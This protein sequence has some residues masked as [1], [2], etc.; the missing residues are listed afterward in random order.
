[1]YPA[2]SSSTKGTKVVHVVSHVY[3]GQNDLK[4]SC[5]LKECISSCVFL[6]F[7]LFDHIYK[8]GNN[9]YSDY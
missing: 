7:V 2:C 1:M 5:E 8:E 9:F 3:L 6:P 4:I